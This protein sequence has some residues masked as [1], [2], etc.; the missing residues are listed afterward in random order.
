M[1]NTHTMPGPVMIDGVPL[2]VVDHYV[3]LGQSIQ[4]GKNS[5]EREASRRIQLGW[6]AYRGGYVTYSRCPYRRA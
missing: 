1:F 4:L 2:E 5:F 3:Y 6:A